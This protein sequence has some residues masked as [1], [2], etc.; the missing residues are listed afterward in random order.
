MF[1]TKTRRIRRNRKI[2]LCDLSGRIEKG[3]LIYRV[4]L[5]GEIHDL[6]RLK[7]IIKDAMNE[8]IDGEEKKAISR[9]MLE[10]L[11]R[12]GELKE[13]I[14]LYDLKIEKNEETVELI[15]EVGESKGRFRMKNGS[16]ITVGRGRGNDL[17]VDDEF[18]QISRVHCALIFKDGR[19]FVED[20]GSK[21]GT[22]VKGRT[23]KALKPHD[24]Y[25]LNEGEIVYLSN[26][27][28]KITVFRAGDEPW[29][30]V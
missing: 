26:L 19:L 13:F 4:S 20:L 11:E 5:F 2:G 3:N 25:P 16:K 27:K 22:F 10:I 24:P 12:L 21:N 29:E 23:L 8:S 14:T 28:M 17:K 9:A 30:N 1:N 18:L 15:I 7:K 6:E